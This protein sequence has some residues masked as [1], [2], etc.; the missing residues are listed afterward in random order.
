VVDDGRLIGMV[1]IRDLFDAVK[2]QLEEDI[3]EREAF[4]FGATAA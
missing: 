4:I 2:H 3:Q 1:S